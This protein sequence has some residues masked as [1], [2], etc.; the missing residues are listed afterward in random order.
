MALGDYKVGSVSELTRTLRNFS[1]GE[2]TTITVYRGGAEKVL[3]I[4]LDEKPQNTE[5][6]PAS[7]EGMPQSGSFEEW[8]NYFAPYFST[9]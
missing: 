3:T 1:A 6:T 5:T 7:T 9:P 4:T 8:Y 2:T